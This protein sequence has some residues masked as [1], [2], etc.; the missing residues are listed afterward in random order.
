M[1][2]R[3]GTPTD[4]P[5]AQ[6]DA[7]A[8]A[9]PARA[10]YGPAVADACSRSSSTSRRTP[11]SSVVAPPALVGGRRAAARRR[12][13]PGGGSSTKGLA[14][15]ITAGS[16]GRREDLARVGHEPL[17]EL[18]L[19]GHQHGQ[20]RCW[21]RAR[22]GPPAATSRR[23]CRGSRRARRR[24]A[25]RCRRRA[26]GRWWPPRPAGARRT[27]RPRSPAARRPGSRPGR[28]APSPAQRRSGSRR[29]A[30]A[31]TTSVPR[32]LRQKAM[33]RAARP[34][35]APASS[36]AVSPLRRRPRRRLASSTQRRV[37][38]RDQPL[39]PRRAVV[40]DLGSTGRPQSAEASRP[41][42]PMVAEQKTNVGIRRRSGRTPA[43]AGAAR[44]P[45]WV[46]KMPRSTC[47]SSTHDVAQAH[48]GT[49]PSARGGGAG[50]RGAS[51]GW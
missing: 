50:R 8:P 41:G 13:R 25:R 4:E 36:P 27:A 15:L 38:E 19:A 47:S 14:G 2:R 29:R 23:W 45:T 44:G 34:P 16:G 20:R 17:V 21:R 31:A 1:R 37:P 18:V 24:R 35:R 9:R 33:A 46:P 39:A 12:R 11:S 3:C 6:P 42:S 26:R 7:A 30:S 32:R 51:R 40:G 28:A 43:A 48:A 10:Q 22:P 5:A 49:W